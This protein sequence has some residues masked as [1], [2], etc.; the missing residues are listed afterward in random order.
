M[1]R[2]VRKFLIGDLWRLGAYESWFSHLASEGLHLEKVG[3]LFARFSKGEHKSIRY[4]IDTI[5][6][7]SISAG[8]NELYKE[9]GWEYVTKLGEFNVFSSPVQ[10]NAPEL[11]TD[12]A[13][14]SHTL[15]KLDDKIKMNTIFIAILGVIIVGGQIALLFFGGGPTLALIK[16]GGIIY[17]T[18]SLVFIITAYWMLRATISIRKLRK[19]LSEGIPINHHA[20]WKKHRLE[21]I[22]I[23]TI[24]ITI[25]AFGAAPQFVQIAMQKTEPL[26]A[27]ST[28]LPIIL[29]ADI[30][31]SPELVREVSYIDKGLDWGNQLTYNWGLFAPLQYET[32]EQ[33]IVSDQVW[34][35]DSGVYSPSVHTQVYK[36]IF[37]SM[38]E[39][40]ISDHITKSEKL[41]YEGDFI[42]IESK[43]F[44]ILYTR[45]FQEE[46]EVFA[47]K[48]KGVIYI[49]YFGYADM[50]VL[51][52]NVK[53]KIGMISE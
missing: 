3:F 7:K 50:D 4:R 1:A 47:A 15:K 40:L 26:P 5:A 10:L 41:F 46:K 35:D 36:L 39:S 38:S 24:I 6:N 14:Q 28:D 2:T 31:Q 25:A 42:P 9:A 16:E 32:N 52:E 11:H 34:E 21:T 29:L 49:N 20:P 51:L 12:P 17:L 33:G 44:D 37:P 18:T 22:I 45:E 27:L 48:G 19:T 8:Q 53:E 13:E 30:E 23:S 43:D